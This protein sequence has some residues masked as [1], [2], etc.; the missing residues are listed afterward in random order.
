M[1]KVERDIGFNVT[2]NPYPY[3]TVS[4]NLYRYYQFLYPRLIMTS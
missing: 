1:E 2:N 4:I 3:F